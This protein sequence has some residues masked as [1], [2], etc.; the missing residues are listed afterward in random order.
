VLTDKAWS[1]CLV[2]LPVGTEGQ[3]V[4]E[5]FGKNLEVKF[6]GTGGR[7]YVCH[8]CVNPQ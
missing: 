3:I 8:T 5:P 2:R 6:K 7:W 1:C 4:R